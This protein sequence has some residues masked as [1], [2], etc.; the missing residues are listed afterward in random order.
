MKKEKPAKRSK[1]IVYKKTKEIKCVLQLVI[2]ADR[3]SHAENFYR[4]LLKRYKTHDMFRTY[5][6]DSGTPYRHVTLTREI[7]FISDNHRERIQGYFPDEF[8]VDETIT[9]PRI[10]EEIDMRLVAKGERFYF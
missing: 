10:L 9:D 7:I 6:N 8:W 5:Y 2:F 3:N 1:N 4:F